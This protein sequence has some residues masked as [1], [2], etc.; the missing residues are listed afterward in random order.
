MLEAFAIAELRVFTTA[1]ELG[2]LG[3]AAVRLHVTQSALS[4]RLAALEQLAGEKLLDRSPQGVR[5]TLAGRQLYEEARRL[6]TQAERV[7]D[8]LHAIKRT[9]PPVLLAVSHSACEAVLGD[10][11]HAPPVAF[12]LMTANSR[13]VRDLVSEGR[14]ELGVAASR[15]S[16]TPYPGVRETHLV[17]D[18]VVLAVP[19]AHP[20]A[21]HDEV[22]LQDFLGTPA[23]TCD[24]ASNSRWTVDAALRELELTLARPLVE[25][26][27]PAAA[28]RAAADLGAPALLS[29]NT[30]RDSDLRVVRVSGLRFIRQFVLLTG[31]VGEPTSE[32]I[33]L[34]E[35]LARQAAI[36]CRGAPTA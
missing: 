27:T 6:L 16:H 19:P 22:A 5:L 7:S 18:E 1:A 34:S 29:L 30:L 4:K 3:R 21:K 26:G 28:R 12:E 15:L 13:M 32:V 2:T 35:H 9:G 36:W 17:D 33:T 14:A 31:A 24:S 25:A 10:T 20:W 11:L 8:V 23:V